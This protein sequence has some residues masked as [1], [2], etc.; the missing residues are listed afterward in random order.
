MKK[1]EARKL[2]LKK[3]E[4]ESLASIEEKS[5][6]VAAVFFNNFS[7]ATIHTVHTFLPILHKKELDTSFIINRL[8][9][10]NNITIVIPKTNFED[11]TLQCLLFDETTILKDNKWGI[12][13]PEGGEL[14]K[15]DTIDLVL[16]PLLAYDRVGNRVGY[17]K[18]FYDRLLSTCRKDVLKVGLSFYEPVEEIEDT[19]EFDIPLDFCVTD[20]RVYEFGK[21]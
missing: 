5:R 3:R 18:G 8:Q 15:E 14:V 12:P 9:K 13:E 11:D 6:A 4:Q 7:F 10:E 20:K 21:Q 1:A 16:I 19:N 2:F 17:G